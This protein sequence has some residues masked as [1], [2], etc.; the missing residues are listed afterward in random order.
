MAC[1][2]H[3]TLCKSKRATIVHAVAETSGGTTLPNPEQHTEQVWRM[4]TTCPSQSTPGSWERWLRTEPFMRCEILKPEA[5]DQTHTHTHYMCGPHACGTT[6][7]VQ[8]IVAVGVCPLLLTSYASSLGE[9]YHGPG[10]L[11]ATTKATTNMFACHKEPQT[12]GNNDKHH[13]CVLHVHESP[14]KQVWPKNC[15]CMYPLVS[16]RTV[17]VSM[18]GGGCHRIEVETTGHGRQL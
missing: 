11:A 12:R 16:I 18:C 9:T 7:T 2:R 6:A 10:V 1:I 4:R 8:R 15:T 17:V 14:S 3:S 5:C 13:T